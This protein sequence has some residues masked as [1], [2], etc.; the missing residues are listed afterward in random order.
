MYI[1]TLIQ[2][3]TGYPLLVFSHGEGP[4]GICVGGELRRNKHKERPDGLYFCWN[5]SGT[6][7]NRFPPFRRSSDPGSL[8]NFLSRD[9]WTPF[10]VRRYR[11][12]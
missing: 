11:L 6:F 2:D 5:P 3:G 7:G 8:L 10:F 12:I 4:D 9:D 1:G